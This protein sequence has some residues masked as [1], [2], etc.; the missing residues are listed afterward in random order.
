MKC[1]LGWLDI[2]ANTDCKSKERKTTKERQDS[3]KADGTTNSS[4]RSQDKSTR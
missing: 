1:M 4:T 2:L 3:K